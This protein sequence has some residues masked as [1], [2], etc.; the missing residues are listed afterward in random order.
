MS[1]PIKVSAYGKTFNFPAGT[2]ADEI[3]S[4][5]N[6]NEHLYNPDYKAPKPEVLDYAKG[7]AS[8]ANKM[9]SG[10]GFLAEKAGA[11]KVGKSIREFGDRGALTLIGLLIVATIS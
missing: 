5:L 10:L 9:V 1:K 7:F 11:D 8:G 3:E 2:S 6:D 4:V